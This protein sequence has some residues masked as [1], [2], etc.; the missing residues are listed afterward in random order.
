MQRFF[1]IIIIFAIL[2]VGGS[3]VFIEKSEQEARA[4]READ[5]A[6]AR[7][8]F[9]DK[10]R[11]AARESDNDGYHRSIRAALGS[12]QEELKKRVYQKAPEELDVAA[13]K[14][15]V[16]RRF[17]EG[18][19]KESQQKS[20]LEAYAIVR[21]AYDTMMAGNWK[22]VLSA[23]GKLD[24]RIDIYDVKRT[25]T[26]EGAPVLEGKFF[27]WG[28]EKATRMSWGSLAIRYWKV[29]K[30]KVKEGREMVEKDV[31]KVLGRVE[32]EA[33]PHIIVQSVADYIPQFP[34]NV[35]IGFF[36]LPVMPREAV[37]ADIELGYT[38]KTS[39]GDSTSDLKW[40]KFKI[41]ESWKLGEGESWDADV[42]EATEDEIAGKEGGEGEE[43][44]PKEE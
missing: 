34:S 1:S 38:A 4:K 23:A 10:A 13:Y 11:S 41:P 24:S 25:K 31:E 7:R 35:S 30:E 22:P 26:E 39:G 21:D 37:Y 29:E 8:T 6:A 36:W 19:L 15:D 5:L 9:A 20:M 40:E 16:E 32:G 17:K 27:F 2:V 28:I 44:A 18:E 42:I 3:W 12:Y 14:T 43:G 33:T